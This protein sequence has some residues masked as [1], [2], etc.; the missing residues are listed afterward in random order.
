MYIPKK[1]VKWGYKRWCRSGISGYVYESEVLR[2]KGTKG[3]PENIQ[4]Q[5]VFGE[6]ENVVLRLANNLQPK[7]NN[8]FF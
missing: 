7:E 4:S 2:G 6:S 5:Y 1:P 8:V 3:T